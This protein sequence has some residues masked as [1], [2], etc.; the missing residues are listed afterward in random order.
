MRLKE[1][2]TRLTDYQVKIKQNLYY[3]IIHFKH[4]VSNDTWKE[5]YYNQNKDP[6]L[7][8][9]KEQL[10]WLVLE[11]IRN[12]IYDT[13]NYI[14]PNFNEQNINENILE[15]L[16]DFLDIVIKSYKNK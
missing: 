13:N 8:E 9:E 16:T 5:W 3:I 11:D 1:D 6:K 4:K 2:F 14:L 15:S 7:E 12:T 10:N